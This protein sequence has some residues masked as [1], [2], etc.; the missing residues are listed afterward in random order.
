M[1][2]MASQELLRKSSATENTQVQVDLTHVQFYCSC[3]VPDWFVAV[4]VTIIPVAIFLF[5]SALAFLHA[6]IFCSKWGDREG[7]YNYSFNKRGTCHYTLSVT[8]EPTT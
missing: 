5:I 2:H 1:K 3:Y 6:S 4:G 8:L 7:V